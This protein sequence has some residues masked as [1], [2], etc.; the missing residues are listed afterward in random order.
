MWDSTQRT[1]CEAS[2][3]KKISRAWELRVRFSSDSARIF[4]FLRA[5]DTFILRHGFRKKTNKTPSK[6]LER[7]MAY[8]E[9]YERRWNNENGS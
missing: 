4:Y 9:D 7:A 6:E 1:L 5:G 8:K 3:R 2:G